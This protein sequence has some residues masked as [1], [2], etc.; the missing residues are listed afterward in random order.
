[1]LTARAF[2]RP[3]SKV[4]LPLFAGAFTTSVLMVLAMTY[5][6]VPLLTQLFQRWLQP[7]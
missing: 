7:E 4:Q 3:A 1:M 6:L 2:V 5:V